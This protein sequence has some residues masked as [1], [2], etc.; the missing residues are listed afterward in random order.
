MDFET[1]EEVDKW[2]DSEIKASLSQLEHLKDNAAWKEIE[3]GLKCRL[4]QYKDKLIHERK[5][6]KIRLM[7]GRC[8]VIKDILGMLDTLIEFK[9]QEKEMKDE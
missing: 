4:A 3:T 5:I 8:E 6:D 9:R 7:Q 1:Q 2:L